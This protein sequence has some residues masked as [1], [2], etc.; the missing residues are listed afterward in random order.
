VRLWFED[1]PIRGV[2]FALVIRRRS[3]THRY[4]AQMAVCLL[5]RLESWGIATNRLAHRAVPV[6]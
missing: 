5:S 3:L 2:R 4:A 1:G 6:P